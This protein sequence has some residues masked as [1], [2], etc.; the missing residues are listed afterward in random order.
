LYR[1]VHQALIDVLAE[2]G[3]DT[4]FWDEVRPAAPDG[5]GAD[6]AYACGDTANRAIPSAKPVTESPTPRAQRP[7]PNE[8]FLCFQ[9]RSPGDLVLRAS[10]ETSTEPAAW[11]KIL[12]SAQRRRH[13]AVLQH[14]SL[15]WGRSNFAPELP[16]VRDLAGTKF[17]NSDFA[18]LIQVWS[19]KLAKVLDFEVSTGGSSP[20]IATDPWLVAAREKF[21]EASWL[22]S[23]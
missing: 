2:R 14:G 1:A 21:H 22:H 3:L 17:A 7:A 16:G 5:R 15:L 19:K 8:P 12:G 9:R 20:A 18:P 4:R 23:R 13:G 11:H 6:E 10:G